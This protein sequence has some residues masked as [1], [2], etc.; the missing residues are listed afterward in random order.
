[1]D[2]DLF[3]R[4]PLQTQCAECG[5]VHPQAQ[6]VVSTIKV[7]DKVIFQEHFCSQECAKNFWVPFG[8]YHLAPEKEVVS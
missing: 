4:E 2:K 1:M 6:T 5:K 3:G 8:M 7:S